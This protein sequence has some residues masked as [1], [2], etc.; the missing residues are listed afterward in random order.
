MAAKG[1]GYRLSPLA[2]EDLRDIWNYTAETWS[3]EQAERYHGELISTLEGLAA[4]RKLGRPVDIRQAYFKYT[5]GA[6]CVFYRFSESAIDIIRILHQ[7]MD[8]SRHL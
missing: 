6:H 5:V 7:K 3:W 4:G 1:R 8:V 2:E